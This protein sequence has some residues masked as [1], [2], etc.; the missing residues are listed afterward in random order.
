MIKD[1]EGQPSPA[2]DKQSLEHSPQ[3]LKDKVRI[4]PPDVNMD[5]EM[6]ESI[7]QE[8]E[9]PGGSTTLPH[10]DDGDVEEDEVVEIDREVEIIEKDIDGDILTYTI[11]TPPNNG[12]VTIT[13]RNKV[14]YTPNPNY[15]GNDLITLIANDG[16]EYSNEFT[17]QLVIKPINDIPY[18]NH[19]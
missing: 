16:I 4:E 12:N 15:H 9:E 6:K 2:S 1:G 18:V 7:D 3:E 8:E 17:I 14:N 19:Q 10:T 11:T 5:E 13:N